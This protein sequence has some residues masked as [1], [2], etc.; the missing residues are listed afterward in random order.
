MCGGSE[1]ARSAFGGATALSVL[2]MLT[3]ATGQANVS[4]SLWYGNVDTARRAL[5]AFHAV[6]TQIAFAP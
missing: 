2:Q 1:D 3:Y 5:D 6:N 4:G